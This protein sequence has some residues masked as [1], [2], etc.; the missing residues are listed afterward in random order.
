MAQTRS[1]RCAIC[2]KLHPTAD[3]ARECESLPLPRPRFAVGS[4]VFPRYT[5][6]PGEPMR[7]WK[8]RVVRGTHAVEYALRPEGRRSGRYI[9]VDDRYVFPSP[10][11]RARA[12]AADRRPLRRDTGRTRTAKASYSRA[13]RLNREMAERRRAANKPVYVYRCRS[14]NHGRPMRFYSTVKNCNVRCPAC[15][16]GQTVLPEGG[17]IPVEFLTAEAP[18]S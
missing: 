13:F 2:L 8:I 14:Q 10:E 15:G 3:D 6:I 17:P 7:V 9:W 4:V 16:A 5:G 11:E 18:Y 12:R 1:R